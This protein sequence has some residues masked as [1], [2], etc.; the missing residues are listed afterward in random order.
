MTALISVVIPSFANHEGLSTVLDRIAGQDSGPVYEVIVVVD[1]DDPDPEAAEK[2]IAGRSP[3]VRQLQGPRP[4]ASANR[5]AGWRAASASLVLFIDNDTL[6]TPSLVRE[7]LEWHRRYPDQ[8]LAVLGHVRWARSVRVTPFMR[9]LDQGIQFDYPGIRGIDAGWGRFY[10]ANISVK[11]AMLERLGG[12][13]EQRFP[14]GYED[15]D[16]AYRARD[17]GLRVFYNRDAV[18]EHLR[19]YDLEFFRRRVRR[20]AAAERAFVRAHPDVPPFFFNLFTDAASRRPAT[21][22]GRHLTRWLPR[23]TPLLGERAW[24][25]ADLYF[26]QALAPEFLS[27]WESAGSGPK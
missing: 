6:P 20:I 22:R 10:S 11:R 7:H 13:D 19:A 2:A 24:S 18:V 1:R 17:L 12:F 27:A 4:G 21:G 9:W 16:L 3:S 5:N 25:S 14:Y 15:L 23:S 8:M 26:A